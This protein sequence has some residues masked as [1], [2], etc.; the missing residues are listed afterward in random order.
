MATSNHTTVDPEAGG[1]V[2]LR[3]LFIYTPV[4]AMTEPIIPPS[5]SLTAVFCA[6]CD[7]GY[8]AVFTYPTAREHKFSKNLGAIW[9]FQAR[10]GWHE[11]SSILRADKC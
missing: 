4:Y 10:E 8:A 1:C 6:V 9:K 5:D 7:Q 2:F 3:N 11:A